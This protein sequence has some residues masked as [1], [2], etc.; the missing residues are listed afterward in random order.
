[1]AAGGDVMA[2][3]GGPLRYGESD[4]ILPSFIAY[5]DRGTPPPTQ[6]W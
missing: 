6:S 1:L 5:G 2:P 3:D 4:L